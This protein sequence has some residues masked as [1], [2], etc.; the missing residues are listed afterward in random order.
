MVSQPPSLS[1]SRKILRLLIA[2]NWLY[3]FGV[4]AC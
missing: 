3:G 4:V 2:L 1:L